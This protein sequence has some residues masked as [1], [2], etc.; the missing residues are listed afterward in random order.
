MRNMQKADKETD[1]KK[2]TTF[3]EKVARMNQIVIRICAQNCK[4]ISFTE[5]LDSEF[6]S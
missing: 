1:R 2:S 5:Y 6:E 3:V 4:L